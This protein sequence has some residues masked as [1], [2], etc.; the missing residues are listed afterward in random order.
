MSGILSID[1]AK[2]SSTDE[3]RYI[4]SHILHPHEWVTILFILWSEKENVTSVLEDHLLESISST[5]WKLYEEEWDFSFVTERYNHFLK[6]LAEIDQKT[7]DIVFCVIKE[8]KLMV[9]AWW[10]GCALIRERDGSVNMIIESVWGNHTFEN[11]SSGIIPE[12]SQIFLISSTID[13]TIGADFFDEC[14]AIESTHFEG[15]VQGFLQR[16]NAKN[17]HLIRIKKET[18]APKS[19][20]KRWQMTL[21]SDIMNDYFFDIKKIYINNPFYQRCKE[22]LWRILERNSN[23]LLMSFLLIGGIIFVGLI[24]SLIQA[25]FGATNNPATDAKNQLLR[26]KT[27]IEEGEKLTSNQAAF[28]KSIKEAESI[29]NA[30]KENNLYL[31][32]TQELLQKAEAMKMELYDI[33]SIDLSKKENI[34]KFNSSEFSPIGIFEAN[35]KLNLI[36]KQGAIMGYIRGNPL[37]K[38]SAYPPGE[39]GVSMDYG[40][41]GIPF[42]STKNNRILTPRQN[43]FTYI[44]VT[45]QDS[46]ESSHRLKTFNGNIYLLDQ[47][48]GQLFKHRPGVNGF[49]QKSDTFPVPIESILDIGIDGGFYALTND[50]KIHRILPGKPPFT[51]LLNKIPGEY[52]LQE[53]GPTD[54]AIRPNLKYIYILNGNKIWIFEPDSKKFSDIR[55]WTYIAQFEIDTEE[56]IRSMNVPRDGLIY[57]VTNLWVYELPFELV[58]KNIILR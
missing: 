3:V 41:D 36:G 5:E 39:E 50:G 2:Y 19:N 43:A 54:I 51:I 52:S 24:Y 38:I 45:G 20:K 11:I 55:S 1:V 22:S 21:Q 31:K 37:P 4:R 42:V 7:T 23:A 57:L 26:A 49:S 18:I 15:I 44:T 30:L 46:W 8:E 12:D 34:F 27:L 25:F 48:S 40:D 47:K 6:N 53:A 32:D 33:K 9:S 58:D 17:L 35:K 16:E 10:H 28:N 29:L 56:E 13:T 14:S